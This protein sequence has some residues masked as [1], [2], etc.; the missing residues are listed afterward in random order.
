MIVFRIK[1][2]HANFKNIIYRWMEE[3]KNNPKWAKTQRKQIQIHFGWSC[4][5]CV[6]FTFFR[7]FYKMWYAPNIFVCISRTLCSIPWTM[8]FPLILIRTICVAW[9]LS[10]ISTHDFVYFEH[11]GIHIWCTQIKLLRF[12]FSFFTAFFFSLFVGCHSQHVYREVYFICIDKIKWIKILIRLWVVDYEN[13]EW[14]LLLSHVRFFL[15]FLFM[16]IYF[17]I[18]MRL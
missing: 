9:H 17:P 4:A 14:L 10:I 6:L 11:I 8:Y 15:L 18:Y 3:N 7:Y 12:Y 2:V 13:Y 16:C 5:L 1:V